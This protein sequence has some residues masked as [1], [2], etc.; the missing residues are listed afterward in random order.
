VLAD[1]AV[2][3][4][5]LGLDYTPAYAPAADMASLLDKEI[6]NWSAFIKEKGIKVE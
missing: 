3:E 6:T 5:L 2:K 4:R 1:E